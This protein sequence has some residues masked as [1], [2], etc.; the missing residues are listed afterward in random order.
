L[1]ATVV[2][3]AAHAA[4][5]GFG[6]GCLWELMNLIAVGEGTPGDTSTF[7]LSAVKRVKIGRG[8]ARRGMWLLIL[9]YVLGIN[10]M[11][12]GYCVSFETPDGVTGRQVV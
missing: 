12:E 1:F 10:S 7:P 3:L 4:V 11:S 5:S 2:L 6:A 8:W 9:P